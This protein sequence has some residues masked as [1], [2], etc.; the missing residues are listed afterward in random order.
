M[1]LLNWPIYNTLLIY[2]MVQSTMKKL[3]KALI[4]VGVPTEKGFYYV[5]SV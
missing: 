5:T 2:E 4:A 3:Q 1:K